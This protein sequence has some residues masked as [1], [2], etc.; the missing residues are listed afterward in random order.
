MGVME[1]EKIAALLF[2]RLDSTEYVSFL[3]SGLREGKGDHPGSCF[4]R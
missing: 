2:R 1:K 3:F 4:W